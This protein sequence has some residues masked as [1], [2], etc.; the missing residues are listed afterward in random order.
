MT[1]TTGCARR[2][3]AQAG[4]GAGAGWRRAP[5]T[6]KRSKS[7]ATDWRCSRLPLPVSKRVPLAWRE[8][9]GH[10]PRAEKWGSIRRQRS[11]SQSATKVKRTS[12]SAGT[13]HTTHVNSRPPAC[14]WTPKER[15][16][17]SCSSG[18][19]SLLRARRHRPRS[20]RRDSTC[21]SRQRQA[22]S[23]GPAR[24]RAGRPEKWPRP[25]ASRLHVGPQ[26]A[27]RRTW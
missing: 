12:Q 26:E 23:S 15:A 18:Q 24:E 9:R 10:S 8:G 3:R 5:R 16:A 27:A 14:S 25:E 20:S 4:R 21:R 11:P 13:T 1:T 6:L 17:R 7:A 19:Q 22:V 2:A